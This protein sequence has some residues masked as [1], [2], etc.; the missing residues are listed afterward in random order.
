MA[1]SCA[2]GP[3]TE[4]IPATKTKVKKGV[5]KKTVAEAAATNEAWASKAAT[6]E[7]GTSKSA[8][9]VAGTSRAAT[10]E[11]AGT[12]KA[13]AKV[14]GKSKAA[15]NEAGPSKATAKVAGASRATANE[16]GTSKATAKVAGTSKAAT[17]EAGP[18]KTASKVAGT[19]KAAANEAGPSAVKA[20]RVGTDC[21]AARVAGTNRGPAKRTGTDRLSSETTAIR[22]PETQS[23]PATAN[24]NSCQRELLSNYSNFEVFRLLEPYTLPRDQLYENEIPVA[25]ETA[26][27]AVYYRPF[28]QRPPK[29]LD[30]SCKEFKR[31]ARTRSEDAQTP[32]PLTP[33]TC[34][35]CGTFYDK[36]QVAATG[37]E[38]A[39]CKYHYGKCHATDTNVVGSPL[40]WTCCRGTPNAVGC[41]DGDVHVWN[42]Y[43]SGHNE[44]TAGFVNVRTA[45]RDKGRSSAAAY[46]VD[47][48]MCFTADGLEVTKVT[49]V[50]VNGAVVYDTLV[51]PERPIVDYNTRFSG[52]TAERFATEP[53]KR[54][55]DVQRDLLRYIGPDTVIVGH[56]VGTDL[57]MLRL[58]HE[59]VID[60]TA[61]YPHPNGESKQSLKSLSDRLL[62]RDIQRGGHDSVEDARAAMELT[63]LKLRTDIEM[64]NQDGW[65]LMQAQ[66]AEVERNRNVFFRP[67]S[68]PQSVG[69]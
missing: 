2:D 28:V 9:N 55:A 15:T 24:R 51:L 5:A 13:P 14:V 65:K 67:S 69:S 26:G 61:L 47:C 25:T 63:L 34:V 46:C 4:D 21:P 6:N 50:D 44:P 8:V 56:G 3:V 52:I 11:T 57:L 18:S 62:K 36:H 53:S 68:R 1:L 37:E 41:T 7:V 42:G 23:V 49:L 35:R 64:S 38:S 66:L 22:E 59:K 33:L 43:V 32:G 16:T 10:N 30:P 45:A 58:I 17:N 27:Q 40:E 54:L 12:S 19:T 20:A 39:I 31:D 29:R 60:T 48:E